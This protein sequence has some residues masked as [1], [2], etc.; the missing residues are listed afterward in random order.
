MADMKPPTP[1]SGVPVVQVRITGG[2]L[3]SGIIPNPGGLESPRGGGVCTFEGL[4]RPEHHPEHGE[5]VCLRYEAAEPLATRRMKI[6]A[7]EIARHHEL[8]HIQIEH[9]IGEVAV[10][11]ASV[12]IITIA[13]HREAAFTACRESI[14]RLKSEIPIWKQECWRTGATWSESTSVLPQANSQEPI[15]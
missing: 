1:T 4:T 7:T 15:R 14:D 8:H 11:E 3:R 9:A 2:P 10:G 6:L 5:L 12:R 13:D